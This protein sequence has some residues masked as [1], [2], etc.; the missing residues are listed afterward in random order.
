MSFVTGEQLKKVASAIK[1]KLKLKAPLA[2]PTF[3]GTPT[4]PTASATTNTTQIATTAF[5]KTAFT[6]DSNKMTGATSSAAGKAGLAPA[7]SAGKQN[8]PLCGDATYKVLPIEGGG[9]GASDAATA[10]KNLGLDN[11]GINLKVW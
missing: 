1:E 5:V 7:P 10:R 2:S 11:I 3:T 8:M 6:N 4:A 9:T